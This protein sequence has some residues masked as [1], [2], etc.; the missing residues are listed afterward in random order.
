MKSFEIKMA[1][2]LAEKLLRRERTLFISEDGK[3]YETIAETKT[4]E[5]L[6]EKWQVIQVFYNGGY[7]RIAE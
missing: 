7:W 6:I 4:T 1:K 2:R 3:C 5:S